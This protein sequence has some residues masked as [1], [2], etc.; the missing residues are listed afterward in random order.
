MAFPRKTFYPP[1]RHNSTMHT[2]AD[3]KGGSK[4]REKARANWLSRY[5]TCRLRKWQ[6]CGPELE[7]NKL[8]KEMADVTGKAHSPEQQPSLHRSALASCE[9]TFMSHGSG[10]TYLGSAVPHEEL[11]CQRDT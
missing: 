11:R 5:Q 2:A 10:A 1:T 4:L 7:K 9:L 8:W 6:A 3:R